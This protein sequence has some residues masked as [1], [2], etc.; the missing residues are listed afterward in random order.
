MHY[1]LHL[2]RPILKNNH[3]S[4]RGYFC[5]Y[6]ENNDGAGTSNLPPSVELATNPDTDTKETIKRASQ[7]R[8]RNFSKRKEKQIKRNTGEE[9]VSRTGNTV[10]K[11]HVGADC[12]CA[13]K[14]FEKVGEDNVKQ[15]FEM[16]WEIGDFSTQNAYLFG[17]MKVST[18]ARCWKT[19]SETS[20]RNVS[21]V[22]YIKS[23][24]ADVSVQES[25][26]CHSRFTKQQWEGRKYPEKDHLWSKH[27]THR[28]T[29]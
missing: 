22:Y 18:V 4:D 11:K 9:N 17:A 6:Q 1:I 28:Q 10:H 21:V 13:L 20:R 12:Q 23:N 29:G 7:K 3:H 24:G 27:S 5:Y 15:T 14:C 26:S 19:T 16:F 8:K 2:T 25:L